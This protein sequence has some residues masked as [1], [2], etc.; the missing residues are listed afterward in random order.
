MIGRPRDNG[1]EYKPEAVRHAAPIS[2]A[3]LSV[4]DQHLALHMLLTRPLI[5][6]LI[7][8]TVCVLLGLR[9]RHLVNWY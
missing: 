9:R 8:T 5:D 1:A 3:A 6:K 2:L 4:L 7:G